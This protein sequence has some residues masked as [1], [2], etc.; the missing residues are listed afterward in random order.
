MK[1][2]HRSVQIPALKAGS[3]LRELLK[4]SFSDVGVGTTDFYDLL[5]GSADELVTAHENFFKSVARENSKLNKADVVKSLGKVIKGEKEKLDLFAEKLCQAQKHCHKKSK[6]MVTG[7]KLA[8]AVKRV[9]LLYRKGSD[10]EQPKDVDLTCEEEVAPP[11]SASSSSSGAENALQKAKSMWEL[12][13]SPAK[14]S[15]ELPMAFSPL[16]TLS[17]A[18]SQDEEKGQEEV[19]GQNTF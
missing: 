7:E 15:K 3:L 2:K 17:V 8:D 18:S 5:L 12:G 6:E 4:K 1:L 16:S 9:A 14:T 13:G 19:R 11:Q 10:N